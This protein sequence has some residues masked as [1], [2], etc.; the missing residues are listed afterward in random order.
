MQNN[1]EV[2]YMTRKLPTALQNYHSSLA[3]YDSIVYSRICRQKA[4]IHMSVWKQTDV[5]MHTI[6]CHQHHDGTVFHHTK[7]AVQT[8]KQR[9]SIVLFSCHLT[10]EHPN[11]KNIQ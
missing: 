3:M 10:N 4:T 9:L 11:I 7:L 2:T 5:W 1:S 8:L 6:L